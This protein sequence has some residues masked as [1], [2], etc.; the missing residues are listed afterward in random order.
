MINSQF[1]CVCV[2]GDGCCFLELACPLNLFLSSSSLIDFMKVCARAPVK[3]QPAKCKNKSQTPLLISPFFTFLLFL[4]SS[5]LSSSTSLPPSSTQPSPFLHPSLHHV[6]LSSSCHCSSPVLTLFIQDYSSLRNTFSS[7]Q[8]L[9]QDTHHI[10]SA[11]KDEHKS[12]LP[13]TVFLSILYSPCEPPIGDKKKT[14]FLTSVMRKETGIPFFFISS[15]SS[16]VWK[17][18]IQ[19]RL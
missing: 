16:M 13:S 1:V 19:N 8:L 7:H 4:L 18:V 17:C 15:S 9:S 12:R 5:F 10:P 2:H 11:R 3:L 14:A 6:S